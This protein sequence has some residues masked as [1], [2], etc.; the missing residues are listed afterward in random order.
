[1]FFQ[2]KINIWISFLIWFLKNVRYA[3]TLVGN[4]AAVVRDNSKSYIWLEVRVSQNSAHYSYERWK[5]RKLDY[6]KIDFSETF[7]VNLLRLEILASLGYE[8]QDWIVD[9]D[10]DGESTC[11]ITKLV[12][13]YVAYF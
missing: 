12:S 6:N 9:R 7:N 3:D 2:N 8:D 1:M 13:I 5:K 11:L 4:P 10:I